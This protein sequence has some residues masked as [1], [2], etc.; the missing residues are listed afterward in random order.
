MCGLKH[1]IVLDAPV[2][3]LDQLAEGRRLG[4]AL[5]VDVF[6]CHNVVGEHLDMEGL[7]KWEEGLER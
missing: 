5:L 6:H 2:P 7:N 1:H 3:K 4:T